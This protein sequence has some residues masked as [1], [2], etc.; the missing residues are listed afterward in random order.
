MK[1]NGIG[2]VIAI[3]LLL[4]VSG[5]SRNEEPA[6]SRPQPKTP[7]AANLFDPAKGTASVTGRIQFEGPVPPSAQI[8]MNADPVCMS[9]HKDPMPTEE[10]VIINGNLANVF[11]YVKEGLEK[12]S[13]APPAEPA[14]LSQEGCRYV[15][16]VGGIMVNQ[17]L[18]ILNNDPTLHNVHCLAEKNPQFNLGQPVKGMESLRT[19]ANPEIMVKFRCDVH[20]WMTSYLGV[21]PHPYFSVT[22][23]DGTF[24]LKGLPP[25][26]YLIE[27]WHEKYGVKSM[28]V[29]LGD[30]E[31]KEISLA[32]SAS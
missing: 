25:G 31:A 4:W 28:K 18:R 12:Y 17:G 8:K 26:E 29:T 20:K 11:V 32:F 22:G 24:S 6:D 21:L 9:L 19:F 1:S 30:R 14:S 27:A 16:H 3:S 15:P 13:F 7:S 10:V 2:L 5:C 23:K